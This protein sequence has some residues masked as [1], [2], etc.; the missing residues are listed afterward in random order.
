LAGA[1]ASRSR[2]PPEATETGA[3]AAAGSGGVVESE[4]GTPV[5]DRVATLGFLNKRNN[6]TQVLVMKTGE[7]RRIGN[8]IVKLATCERTAPW[9][10]PQETGAFVQLFV[11]ERATT[12]EKLAWHKVF[13]GWLFKNSPS[14]NVV[15]HPA[16]DV[17]VKDCAMKFP[18]EEDDPASASSAAK[19]AGK[20]S[21][22]PAPATA[23]SPAAT[24]AAPKPAAPAR[25]PE[26]GHSET[27]W[28]QHRRVRPLRVAQHVEVS[29]LRNFDRAQRGQVRRGELAIEQFRARSPQGRHQPGQRHLGRVV[30]PA[31]HAFAAEHAGEAHAIEPANQPSVGPGLD[32][33][34]VSD[35]VQLR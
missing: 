10:D 26:A 22:A 35:R 27:V 21:T 24:P 31:E 28:R 5:K 23:P 15:E 1:S 12:Q 20:P 17:W 33:M 13:S 18:G 9:E 32:R 29:F 11:E 6:I 2:A 4:Y 8:A 19:P 30:H 16:Y 25:Y 14:L 34:G 3:P 7:S